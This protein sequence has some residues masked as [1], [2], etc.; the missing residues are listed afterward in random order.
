LTVNNETPSGTKRF[1]SIIK[2]AANARATI[3]RFPFAILS[4][5]V[6][7]FS[8]HHLVGV[9]FESTEPLFAVY[10]TA[11]LGISLFFSL[12]M[13]GEGR[14]WS[15]RTQLGVTMGGLVALVICYVTQPTPLRGAD[16]YR[17]WLLLAALHLFASFAPFIG[18]RGEENGFWQYNKALLLRGALAAVYSGVL[19]IGLALALAA[20]DTLLGLDVDGDTYAQL[21]FWIAF[22]YSSWFFLAGA[23]KDV[24]ALDGIHEYPTGLRIFTQF[25]L[26]PLVAVY[27]VILYAYVVKIL[28]EWN[29]PTGWVTYP[30]IGLSITGMLALLLV[31]PIRERAENAW[32]RN[33]SRFFFWS[34]YALIALVAV[35]IWTRVSD[36]GITELRYLVIVATAW[37]LGITIYFTIRR[38]REI[39][40]IP[41]VTAVDLSNL[42]DKYLLRACCVECKAN[43]TKYENPQRVNDVNR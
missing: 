26:I 9:G 1:H 22:V 18:R 8:A 6:T 2:L 27:L 40:V 20:C 30:V 11:V 32:I 23:P 15:R 36:Y 29:L 39:R 37:L 4:A 14:G 12:R 42:L 21:W 33:Y 35:A 43:N 19:Y 5:I 16:F 3:E 41:P 25:L 38:T 10:G 34:L 31:Y 17:F 7:A 24:R 13:L 28:V